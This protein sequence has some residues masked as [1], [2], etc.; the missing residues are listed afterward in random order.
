[1][2]LL[3]SSPAELQVLLLGVQQP[4]SGTGEKGALQ[5]Q[6]QLHWEAAWIP[7]PPP[8]LHFP[9]TR[10]LMHLPTEAAKPSG[11][12]GLCWL[13]LGPGGRQGPVGL[14]PRGCCKG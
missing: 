2:H 1:M 3:C 13:M 14:Q 8:P 6:N 10:G 5:Q 12:V 7:P 4:S 9:H 11:E